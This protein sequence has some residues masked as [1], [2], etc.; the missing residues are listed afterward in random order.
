METQPKR[1]EIPWI[2]LEPRLSRDQEAEIDACYE[3]LS[4]GRPVSEVLEEL[5]RIGTR[6]K[7]SN[8]DQ[9]IELAEVCKQLD[10]TPGNPGSIEPS[11]QIDEASTPIFEP[12]RDF[13]EASR[14]EIPTPRLGRLY[15]LFCRK[16]GDIRGY[17]VGRP[18][19]RR[20]YCS[21]AD[22][23]GSGTRTNQVGSNDSCSGARTNQ[24]GLNDICNGDSNARESWR[25]PPG[26]V[27][28]VLGEAL[29]RA[30]G[31]GR[32]CASR[33]MACRHL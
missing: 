21:P 2:S 26:E 31:P 13:A 24:T 7:V 18:I 17:R 8:A 27:R 23:H 19:T 25:R 5:R 33:N 3:L 12:P 6:G 20:P 1:E 28:C 32:R 14:S 10:Q 11:D 9:G 16:L 15:R 30:R 4:S 22:C 29:F